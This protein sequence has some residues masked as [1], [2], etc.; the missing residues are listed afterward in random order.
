[1]A[2]AGSNYVGGFVGGTASVVGGRLDGA[3]GRIVWWWDACEKHVFVGVALET[4]V[5][6]DG[7]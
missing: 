3:V 5:Q 4:L 2:D 6:V 1:M 7:L